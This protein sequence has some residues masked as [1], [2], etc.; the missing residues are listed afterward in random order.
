MNTTRKLIGNT[1]IY[2]LATV[3]PRMMSFLLVPLYTDLLPVGVYGTVSIIFSWMV[4]FNIVLSY[5]METAVFRFY[6]KEE[7]Q[8][9]K[10]LASA[11]GALLISSS[12]FLISTLLARETLANVLSLKSEYLLPAIFILVL[13]ALVVVP[14]ARLRILQKAK[15]YTWIKLINVGLNLFLNILFLWFLPT[16]ETTSV[17]GIHLQFSDP[18]NAILAANLLASGLTFIL[19]LP[20]YSLLAAGWDKKLLAR[21]LR[22][23]YP[24][25]IAGL[26][27]AVNETFDR[28]LLDRLLPP[29]ISA[30]A[31]GAYSACYK[32]AMFVTLFSTA[33]RLGIEPFFFSKAKDANAPETYATVTHYFVA[34]GSWVVLGVV[35]FSEVLKTLLIRDAAYWEAMKVVPVLLF[36][37]LFLG[38]YHNLSV[39][40]K[41]TDKTLIG[42]FISVVGAVITLS[43]N[44]WLIPT[45]SY[46]GSAWAT[47]AAYGSM[48]L[49]SLYWGKKYL[50]IPYNY[51]KTGGYLVLA[52]FFA[53][54]SF[55]YWDQIFYLKVLLFAAYTFLLLWGERKTLLS[56]VKR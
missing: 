7:N 23:A 52:A 56:Y 31:V 50:P 22:Y 9:N 18:V 38:I 47:L 30:Q 48:M 15:R 8:K 24:V 55:Y 51:P 54:V 53:V 33:F 5:G 28:I 27:F 26:A 12:V 36:A 37:N 21:M 49:L 11:L 3:L 13:D 39:A 6:H 17:A 41:V 10:V 35:T 44:F 2:G 25:L 19:L 43:L 45:I 4:L 32:L 20:H 42:A 34:L 16:M 46:M 29:G 14:F 1:F 40:Y